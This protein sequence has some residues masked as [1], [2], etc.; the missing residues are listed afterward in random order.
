MGPFQVVVVQPQQ[1]HAQEAQR[2]RDRSVRFIGLH[3]ASSLSVLLEMERKPQVCSQYRSTFTL[4]GGLGSLHP[5]VL[6]ATVCPV[7]IHTFP[8]H[9]ILKSSSLST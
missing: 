7:P 5:R 3:G 1:E 9:L 6:P 4:V 2:V 8:V